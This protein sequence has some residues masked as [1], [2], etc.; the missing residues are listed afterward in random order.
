MIFTVQAA[1]CFRDT[2]AKLPVSFGGWQRI[3]GQVMSNRKTGSWKT[4]KQ[5]SASSLQIKNKTKHKQTH[6]TFPPPPHSQPV[7]MHRKCKTSCGFFRTQVIQ[8]QSCAKI[9]WHHQSPCRSFQ[10][11]ACTGKQGWER[12][13]ETNKPR[14][15]TPPGDMQ[16][17]I[18]GQGVI[19][20]S[21]NSTQK[22][23]DS[24]RQESRR[25]FEGL[26][27]SAWDHIPAQVGFQSCFS[28]ICLFNQNTSLQP[29]LK[30]NL[31]QCSLSSPLCGFQESL[32]AHRRS[33]LS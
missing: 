27:L 1:G 7:Q 28:C 19:T 10:S 3:D 29:S 6:Q 25:P 23:H 26:S 2:Q 4:S 13:E 32:P 21:T 18:E 31:S 20:S 16:Q 24:E 14:D 33:T 8:Q 9:N 5:V 22:C 30:T 17:G 12:K 15:V 11:Q